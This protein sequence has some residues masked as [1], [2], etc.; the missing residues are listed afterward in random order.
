M[1][2]DISPSEYYDVVG[3]PPTD[4]PSAKR[5]WQLSERATEIERD[6]KRSCSLS[7]ELYSSMIDSEVDREMQ[8]LDPAE[9]RFFAKCFSD[10]YTPPEQRDQ[11]WQS[12]REIRQELS[13]ELYGE[14]MDLDPY[15]PE[16]LRAK[17]EQEWARA[18]QDL[19]ELSQ[20]TLT[21]PEKR[22]ESRLPF[23]PDSMEEPDLEKDITGWTGES[24]HYNDMGELVDGEKAYGL[25]M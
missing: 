22:T 25:E 10:V 4:L 20:E 11:D 6:A 17:R 5:M 19:M 16:E 1:S 14:E 18:E 2:D 12:E 24:Y 15:D 23:M 13:R 9:Q 8:H 7:Y 3:T 21:D